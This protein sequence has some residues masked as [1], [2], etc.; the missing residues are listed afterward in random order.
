MFLITKSFKFDAAHNLINYKG[1]CENIHGHTY[2]L[3]VSFKGKKQDNGLVIDF[4]IIK[5]IIKETILS[6]LDHSYINDIIKIST[7]EN[8]VEWIWKEI[9]KIDFDSNVELYEIK[10]WEGPNSFVT[11]RGG[12]DFEL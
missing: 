2:F 8:I 11:Y 12:K 7:A 4:S 6:K 10:L 9:L 3:E 1:K 5:K